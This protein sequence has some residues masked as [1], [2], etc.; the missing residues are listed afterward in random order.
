MIETGTSSL[1]QQAFDFLAAAQA[2]NSSPGLNR[3]FSE[4]VG[5]LGY[6]SFVCAQLP[7]AGSA[8]SRDNFFG[9]WDPL[10][11]SHYMGNKL[12]QDDPALRE[13]M[14]RTD[15]FAWSDVA[16]WREL[17]PEE[18]RV[19]DH[20]RDFGFTD[21]FTTPMRNLDGSLS[22]VVLFG[23]DTDDD[24]AAR[25]AL[26]IMSLYYAGAARRIQHDLTRERDVH[27]TEREKEV[28][29]L[30]AAG[31]RQSQIAAQLS[32]SERTVEHHLENARSRMGSST[33]VQLCVDAIR[34]GLVYL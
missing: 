14:R 4:Q 9:Q 16:T 27:L 32:I 2:A 11:E 15:P 7:G 5:R 33:S 18:R 31:R 13:A 20:A 6:D 24:P 21:G 25:R 17:S 3:A 23:R 12:Y 29:A 1:S 30:L 22:L 8:P 34:M 19:M 28:I 10:W 26:H